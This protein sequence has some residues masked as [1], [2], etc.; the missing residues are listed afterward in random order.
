[1]VGGT[2]EKRLLKIVAKYADIYNHPFAPTLEVQRRLNVLKDHCK[3]TGRTYEDIERSVVFRCLIR[4][5]EEEINDFIL[6]E[7]N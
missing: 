1:M 3:S 2:G 6:K 5:S 7:K 4:E